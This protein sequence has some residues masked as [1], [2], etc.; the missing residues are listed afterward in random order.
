MFKNWWDKKW[1]YW[2]KVL[3]SASYHARHLSS[4]LP[5]KMKFLTYNV[6]LSCLKII[7]VFLDHTFLESVMLGKILTLKTFKRESKQYLLK[8]CEFFVLEYKFKFCFILHIG[9]VE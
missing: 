3:E 6:F 8:G 1:E 5:E 2:Q 9:A 7:V 4:L